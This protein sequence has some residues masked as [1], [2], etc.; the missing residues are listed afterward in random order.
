MAVVLAGCQGSAPKA[1]S[2]SPPAPSHTASAQPAPTA[3]IVHAV[4]CAI[5]TFN[6]VNNTLGTDV[7]AP[8]VTTPSVDETDCIYKGP[9]QLVTVDVLNGQAAAGFAADKLRNLPRG[10]TS[11]DVAGLA[12][13][14]YYITLPPTGDLPAPT[15]ILFALK[16]RTA[17]VVSSQTS[18]ASLQALMA[19]ALSLTT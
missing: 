2:P 3:S 8:S 19:K 14:A 16:G 4:E 7:S 6:V 10:Q 15:T 18:L 12:D 17:L 5:V 1:A 9:Q 11:G 13:Q